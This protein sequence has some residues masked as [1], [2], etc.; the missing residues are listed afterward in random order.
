MFLEPEES[1]VPVEE[2]VVVEGAW[3][4]APKQRRGSRWE[5]PPPLLLSPPHLPILPAA[6]AH[7]CRG[8]VCKRT[9]PSIRCV[10]LPSSAQGGEGWGMDRVGRG[11]RWESSSTL[12]RGGVCG[13]RGRTRET[14]KQICRQSVP[15]LRP[16]ECELRG[17]DYTIS[18]NL[19]LDP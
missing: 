14:R 7:R 3:E 6:R 5:M 1:G 2:A 4:A 9:G 16:W 18:R 12:T 11:D 15:A 19:I 8:L 13:R 17:S 10:I